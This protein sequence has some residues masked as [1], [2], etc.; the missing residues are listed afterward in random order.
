MMI[1]F[2]ICAAV[3]GALLLWQIVM[4][5]VG[6]GD[7]GLDTDVGHDFGGDFHGDAG[8][9]DFHGGNAHGAADVHGHAEAN[10]LFGVL[11]FRTIV[12]ALTFFGL[13]GLASQTAGH[14]PPIVLCVAITAGAGALYAVY[15]IMRS[16]YSMRAEGTAHIEDALGQPAT[17]YLKIPAG[18]SGAGKIQ[19]NLQD[20]TMEYHA[21]T[22]GDDLPT[23]ANVVVVEVVNHDTVLVEPAEPTERT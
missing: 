20:R 19:I 6:M 14:S 3:G 1:V 13:A 5:L 21:V 4:T 15:W 9:H 8:G 11:S 23:G 16:L 17:V 22:K 2:G 12:A 7:H 10:W 18:E